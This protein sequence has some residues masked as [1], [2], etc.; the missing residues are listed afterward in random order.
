MIGIVDDAIRQRDQEAL[1][2]LPQI[3]S[4]LLSNLAPSSTRQGT[5]QMIVQQEAPQEGASIVIYFSVS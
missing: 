3:P 2:N 1:I 5:V 4:K